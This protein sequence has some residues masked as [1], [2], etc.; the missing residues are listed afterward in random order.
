MEGYPQSY[1]INLTWVVRFLT[2]LGSSSFSIEVYKKKI[3][4]L[5]CARTVP[6]TRWYSDKPVNK[7]QRKS[8]KKRR[9]VEPCLCWGVFCSLKETL[10]IRQDMKM[11]LLMYRL[12]MIKTSVFVNRT[13]QFTSHDFLGMIKT[14]VF[15]NRTTQ[16]TSPWLS[17]LM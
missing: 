13:T 17:W 10:D 15:V 1:C 12:G 16:F 5:Y 8:Q 4:K 14:S 9:R 3:K 2:A 6:L 7:Q 11:D